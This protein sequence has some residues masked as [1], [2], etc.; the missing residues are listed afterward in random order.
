MHQLYKL[1]HPEVFQ[2]NLNRKKYFEGWYFKVVSHDGYRCAF[3]PG[4][5]LNKN[6]SHAFIQLIDGQSGETK[7]F[8]FALN[9]FRFNKK[10][11][12]VSIGNSHFSDKGLNIDLLDEQNTIR[13]QLNFTDL[14]PLTSKLLS[15]GIMGWYAFVPF[16]QCYHGIV[17]MDHVVNG[18]LRLNNL[19]FAFKNGKGYIEKDWGSS[20]PAAWIWTQC[21]NFSGEIVSVMFSLAKI[22]WLGSEFDGFLCVVCTKNSIFRFATYTGAKITKLDQNEKSILIVINDR[23]HE[24]KLNVF[25]SHSGVLAAPVKGVMNRTIHESID[26][27]VDVTLRNKTTGMHYE[28]KGKYAGCEVVG[29]AFKIAK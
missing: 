15:P 14:R 25:R 13:G 21:N 9:Q 20:M 1:Y 10:K 23:S 3:I 5:S 8:R 17:S 16:M 29:D 27:R 26:A 18:S 2:G 4:I 22:P 19:E 24:L 12:E 28:S 6:D 11:L 7:Y